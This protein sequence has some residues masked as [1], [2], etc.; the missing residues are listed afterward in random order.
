M[1]ARRRPR[2]SAGLVVLGCWAVVFLLGAAGE[3]FDVESL[4]RVADLKSLFLR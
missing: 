1:R 2:S 3:F 4:R